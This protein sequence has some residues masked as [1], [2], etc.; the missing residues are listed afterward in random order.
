MA[1]TTI[2]GPVLVSSGDVFTDESVQQHPLGAM[3]ISDDGRVFRYV[4]AGATALVPGKL[5]QGVGVVANHQNVAVQAAAA[6]GA[7]AVTVTLGAT[8]ATLN[9]YAGGL[10]VVND[11][12]GEGYT[13]RIKSNPAADASATLTLTLDDPILIALTTSSEACLIPNIY[14]GV[15]V[16]DSPPTMMPVGVPLKAITAS[17]FGWLQTRGPVSCLNGDADITVNAM[18]SPSGATDGAVKIG[19]LADGF[20]GYALQAGVNTEYR[21][22]FLMLD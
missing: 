7:T 2:T 21:T 14:N 20:V 10:L 6:I 9:Q 13:Y 4:K 15:V 16:H 5:Q 19:V 12:T 22:I 1:K 8:A 18:L 17:Q 11:V 3:G